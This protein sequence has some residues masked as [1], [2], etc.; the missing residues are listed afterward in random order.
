M[1][2]T[3]GRTGIAIAGLVLI[4]IMIA[5]LYHV[6]QSNKPKA[7]PGT[8]SAN[9]SALDA[10]RQ[11]PADSRGRASDAPGQPTTETAP[12]DIENQEEEKE[13]IVLLEDDFSTEATRGPTPVKVVPEPVLEPLAASATNATKPEAEEAI[14]A[15]EES[16]PE[17][18]S[19][20]KEEKEIEGLRAQ[21]TNFAVPSEDEIQVI[22]DEID[23]NHDG[24]LSMPE[25][26]KAMIQRKAEF[27]LKPTIVLRAFQKTDTDNDGKISRDEF[28]KFIRLVSYYKNLSSVFDAMDTDR[29]RRLNKTEFLKAS[30]VLEIDDP[31]AIFQEMDENKGGYIVF[32]EFCIWMAEKRHDE[33]AF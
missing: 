25:V 31:D 21:L 22:F 7:S 20:P 27:D 12:R 5:L 28:F 14:D 8:S 3:G 29:N 26:E 9:Q 10:H 32:D 1:V 15:V 18:L 30:K 6:H 24:L 23:R 17:E 13:E 16:T 19:N 2:D 11:Q 4:S 33:D